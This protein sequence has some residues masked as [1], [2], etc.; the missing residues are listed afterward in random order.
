[1]EPFAPSTR[2]K[3]ELIKESSRY[4]RGTLKETLASEATH[5][6]EDE[7][8]LL[9][10]H[11]TYQ[12]DDRDLR[13]QLRQ[14]GKEPHY[15]FMV[16]VR[17]P[18]GALTAEQYLAC[19]ELASRYA[20]ST[21]RLT[22]RQGI[23]FHGV[24][25]RGLKATI[26]GINQTLLTTLSACGD[27]SRNV[28]GCP[29]PVAGRRNAQVVE[30]ARQ[31]ADHL[32]PRTKAYHE[33]WL[34]GER[35]GFAEEREPVEPIYGKVYLPRK[36]KIGIAMPEDNCVDVY[37]QDIGLV[38]LLQGET[39]E[40]FNV[41]IGGGMGMTHG[42]KETFPRLADPMAFVTSD[43]LV[44]V[45]E[46]IV[47]VQRDHGDRKDRKHARMKYLVQEWGVAKFRAEVER[48]M[49][50]RL[51]DPRSMEPLDI[52]YHL[53]WHPQGDGRWFLGLSIENGRIKDEGALQLR[54]GLRAVVERFRIS[55]RVTP[56]QDL[57]LTD[58]AEAQRSEIEAL[59][60]SHG[61]PLLQTIANVQRY[62]MACPALPTCG[63]ALTDSERALPSIID[64]LEVELRQ[65][66]LERE[67]FS[68]RM[69]GCP[70]GCARPYLGDL[71]FVGRTP[72][73]YNIYVGGD[74][75]G[76]R[77]NELFR[78]RVPTERLVPEVLP[79]FMWFKETRKPGEAFGDFCHRQ[80]I[81]A[82]RIYTD[83]HPISSA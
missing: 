9:K 11:G 70:N 76:N 44:A 35:V 5:F 8:Q 80:G 46:T 4:L 42:D 72:G 36:F 53:G 82:L 33:I 52:D 51:A 47:T 41:L 34:N 60:T 37:S 48:R 73:T 45:A 26:A 13:N 69:T 56:M 58:V 65:L 38:A 10:F 20:N 83:A 64:Q 75:G 49:G 77:L 43:Q 63:L 61:V 19:D 57:L 67:V 79:L 23:Q 74:F 15:M 39:L 29:A 50:R 2:S 14:Q 78:E 71:G 31:L 40:G 12:Q 55:L 16:R 27:V 30:Y 17:I 7:K 25:K 66:G 6:S 24:L 59:L 32:S 81:E 62:A 28:M 18:S 68:V 3:V 1:M 21:L 22:T 54:S